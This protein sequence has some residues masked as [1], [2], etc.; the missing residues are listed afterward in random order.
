MTDPSD[1][2]TAEELAEDD[3]VTVTVE[4]GLY[5]ATDDDTGISSQG[6]SED[7]ALENLASVLATYE[8]GTAGS[9]DDWL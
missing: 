6:G 7:E 8:E 3:A 5:V 9:G 4:D 1:E 2:P